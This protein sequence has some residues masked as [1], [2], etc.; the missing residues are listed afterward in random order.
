MAEH[1]GDDGLKQALFDSRIGLGAFRRSMCKGML[2][3]LSRSPMN[4]S[5][6][7]RLRR[8]ECP[9]RRQNGKHPHHASCFF[10]GLRNLARVQS[11]A[12]ASITSTAEEGRRHRMENNER[13]AVNRSS[14]TSVKANTWRSE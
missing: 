11:G 5:V 10:L 14:S 1:C 6:D 2:P 3:I 4:F 8:I 7:F 9:D 12:T 13:T